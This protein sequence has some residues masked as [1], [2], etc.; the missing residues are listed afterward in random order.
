MHYENPSKVQI[1]L[2]PVIQFMLKICLYIMSVNQRLN[3]GFGRLHEN[4]IQE[5]VSAILIVDYKVC[6]FQTRIGILEVYHRLPILE[7]YD[8]LSVTSQTRLFIN[9]KKL[10]SLFSLK[11]KNLMN[12]NT[13]ESSLELKNFLPQR[14]WTNMAV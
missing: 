5:S 4:Q 7:V 10:K 14:S 13:K 1:C 8:R 6:I 11:N 2:S 3:F 9:I 12:D